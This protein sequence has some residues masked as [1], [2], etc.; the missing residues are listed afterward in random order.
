[1]S[2]C[3]SLLLCRFLALFKTRTVFTSTVIT[4]VGQNCAALMQPHFTDSPFYPVTLFPVTPVI[5]TFLTAVTVFMFIRITRV[6]TVNRFLEII[7]HMLANFVSSSG[8]PPPVSILSHPNPVQ[9]P[10]SHS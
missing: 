3:A 7:L 2:Q 1:V 6:R 4:S 9:T 8:C 10:T 5:I